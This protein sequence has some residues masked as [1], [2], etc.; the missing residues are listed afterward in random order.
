MADDQQRECLPVFTE[1]IP[2]D[3]VYCAGQEFSVV[4]TW[5]ATRKRQKT[6]E[7]LERKERKTRLC[8][9]LQKKTNTKCKTYV[10]VILPACEKKIISV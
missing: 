3:C 6:E 9:V 2:R 7:E 10:A 4:Y 5:L 8:Y 1:C